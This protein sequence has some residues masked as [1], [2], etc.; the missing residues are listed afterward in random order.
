MAVVTVLQ[1]NPKHFQRSTISY[2]IEAMLP[3]E[4][5]RKK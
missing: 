1:I 5:Q 4:P 3:L 2:A